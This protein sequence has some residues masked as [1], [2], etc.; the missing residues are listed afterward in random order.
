MRRLT[1]SSAGSIRGRRTIPARVK[2][3]S[4]H[5]AATRSRSDRAAIPANWSPDF[6]SL[7][8]AK[9]SRRSEK[10]NCSIMEDCLARTPHVTEKVFERG[11]DSLSDPSIDPTLGD[12]VFHKREMYPVPWRR[13]KPG[14]GDQSPI[15]RQAAGRGGEVSN[16]VCRRSESRPHVQQPARSV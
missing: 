11:A 13:P 10:S 4:S 15:S 7:A 6:S 5:F 8:L 14:Q 2:S 12:G 9:S 1:S 16:Y 3:A